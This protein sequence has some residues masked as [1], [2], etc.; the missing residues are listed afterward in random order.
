MTEPDQVEFQARVIPETRPKPTQSL[1]VRA[2]IVAGSAVLLVVGAVAAMGAGAPAS[3][4]GAAADLSIALEP[5]AG[6][7]GG[8]TLNGGPGMRGFGRAHFGRIEITAIN[9]SNLSL[10][11]EDGWSRTITVDGDTEI[12][13]AGETAAL[14]DLAVGDH[15][16]FAQ[17]RED[18]G[19]FTITAVNVVLPTLGGEVTAVTGNTITVTNKDGATGTIHVDADTTYQ[20]NGEAAAL[21]DI[22]VG[23]F[24]VAEG[25]LRVDGSLDADVVH[26]GNR[27]FRHGFGPGRGFHGNRDA[28]P[29]ATPTPGTSS[30]VS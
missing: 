21:L 1:P 22:E 5:V 8:P 12:T 29:N 28:D 7:D 16:A 18:D 3:I 13:K 20:A 4:N 25:S 26:S 17:E 30:S 9:G 23:D 2:G 14:T 19:T 27:M 24:V 11:T 10:E 6:L 15:I